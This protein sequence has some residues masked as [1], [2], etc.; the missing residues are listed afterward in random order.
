MSAVADESSSRLF[1]LGVALSVALLVAVSTSGCAHG[2]GQALPPEAAHHR[3]TTRDGFS[4]ELVRYPA[5]G[6]PSGPPVL[7]VHGIS[8]NGRN[9]DF[10]DGLSLPRWL[11]ERGHDAWVLSIRGTGESDDPDPNAGRISGHTFDTIWREDLPAAIGYVREKTGG[12]PIDYIGHSMGGMLA[13][14]YLSQ[15]GEGL[16]RIV[17]LGSPTRLDHGSATLTSALALRPIVSPGAALPSRAL[18]RLSAPVYGLL[19]DDL[20]TLL[21][22]NPQNV[23]APV[24]RRFMVTGV[25]DV[26]GALLLQL[27]G[28]VERGWFGSSDGTLDFRAGLGSVKNPVLVVAGKLDRFGTPMAAWDAYRSLGGEKRWLMMARTHGAVAD[29][30]HMDFLIGIRAPTELWPHLHDFLAR[31]PSRDP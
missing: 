26:S 7:L 29:Y 1:A 14:A 20:S 23:P 10:E 30:G 11:A 22:L 2:R 17:T 21:L 3:V 9:M 19:P 8:A 18:S 25:D 24:W 5:R 6:A 31:T 28:M 16:D 4:L 15:G 13:Y 12:G 27:S